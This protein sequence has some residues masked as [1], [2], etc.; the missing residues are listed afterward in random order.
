MAGIVRVYLVRVKWGE[1]EADC[2]CGTYIFFALDGE[3]AS[4]LLNGLTGACE[5]DTCATDARGDVFGAAEP[6]ED[7]WKL[8]VGYACSLILNRQDGPG[9]FALDGD[10]NFAWGRVVLNSI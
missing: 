8:T 7:V 1:G 3:G 5:T 10:C 9:A 6:L 4:M 2:E